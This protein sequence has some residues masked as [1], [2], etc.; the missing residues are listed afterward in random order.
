MITSWDAQQIVTGDQEHPPVL[1]ATILYEDLSTGLRA[2]GLF[3]RITRQLN[4]GGGGEV[5]LL[6][7]DLLGNSIVKSASE[8]AADAGL[9][10]VSLH[11]FHGLPAHVENWVKA[12]IQRKR[13][14]PVAI[15][16]LL[17]AAENDQPESNPVAVRL[18]KL[19]ASNNVECFSYFF[20]PDEPEDRDNVVRAPR[21]AMANDAGALFPDHR[22]ENQMRD[23]GINE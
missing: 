8:R 6:R 12:W 17:D 20:E 23:W 13:G 14:L 11:G 21:I 9:V 4:F 2:N 10:I 18:L 7:M 3:S 19:A 16:L 1:N 5:E 15:V 22:G